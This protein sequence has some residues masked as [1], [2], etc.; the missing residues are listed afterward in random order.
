[1]A[2]AKVSVGCDTLILISSRQSVPQS[3]KK[4]Q[5]IHQSRLVVSVPEVIKFKDNISNVYLPCITRRKN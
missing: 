2:I 1:M 3:A 4:T 5:L